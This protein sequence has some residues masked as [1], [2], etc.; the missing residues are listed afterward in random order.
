MILLIG[1][2]KGGC[3]KTTLSTNI[4][5]YLATQ[6]KDVLLIDGNREQGNA[7]NWAAKRDDIDGLPGVTCIEKSGN[8]AKAI[9]D[10][11]SKYDQIIVDTGGQD[12]KEFRT[13]LYAADMVLSPF[14]CS[15]FALDTVPNVIALIEQAREANSDLIANV[16]ITKA[17][18]HRGSATLIDETKELLSNFDEFGV[19]KT[20]IYHRTEYI[21]TAG[22]TC[23]EESKNMK[24]KNEIRN[25]IQELY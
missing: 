10:L 14:E 6:G 12:S 13:A 23:V 22:G 7:T 20:V 1:G 9:S 19:L 4:A 25:L 18:T 5:G 24:A 17:P 8:L 3:G 21:Y 16:V 11:S 15:Q 2:Q